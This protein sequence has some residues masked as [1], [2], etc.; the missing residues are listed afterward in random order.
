M[1]HNAYHKHGAYII[2]NADALGFAMPEAVGTSLLVIT[3]IGLKAFTRASH[4]PD[5]DSA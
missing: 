1:A 3:I 5:G 2:D 4:A